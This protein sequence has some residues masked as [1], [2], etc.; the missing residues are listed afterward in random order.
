MNLLLEHPRSTADG[1]GVRLARF[2]DELRERLRAIPGVTDVGGVDALPLAP[3]LERGGSN[4][5]FVIVNRPDEIRSFEDGA[6]L[7]RDPTRTGYADFRVA[8]AG[9]FRAMG[10]PLVRGRPFTDSDSPEAPH[11]AVISESLAKT[12]WPDEDPIG[13]LIN[14]AGIDGDFRVF[15]IVG[16]VGDVRD[17]GLDAPPEPT[18]YGNSR[19]RVG[20][21]ARYTYV[22]HGNFDPA[23]AM[24]SA[25]AAV[26]ELDPT[27]PPS[28]RMLDQV[29]SSSLADRRFNLLLLGVFAGSALL[30]AVTGIYGVIAY[31]VAQQTR[32]I[33]IRI[34]LG[35]RRNDVV[36]MVLWRGVRLT[37][38]GIGLGLI[39][40]IWLT[41]LMSRMLFDIAPTDP[42]TF[43]GIA[44]LMLVV[45]V[46]ACYLPARRATTVDPMI[47]LRSE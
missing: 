15:T 33:G 14:F 4:G 13:K 28:F 37:A 34:A 45:T 6:S 10:I 46:V 31:L 41:R 35:A 32:D 43:S 29:V 17:R 22:M 36:R 8:D 30:L 18:F 25:R 20:R 24:A 21:T 42:L 39:A 47:A 3:S 9:Y 1:V 11:V 27:V 26:R 5:T 16:I 2:H 23:A 38:V 19:Q 44:L 12:R 40:A 7:W